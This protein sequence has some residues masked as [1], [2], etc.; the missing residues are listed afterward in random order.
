MWYKWKVHT[1]TFLSY[2]SKST[3]IVPQKSSFVKLLL[4]LYLFVPNLRI[5]VPKHYSSYSYLFLLWDEMFLFYFILFLFALIFPQ[6]YSFV[7][8]LL[9]QLSVPVCSKFEAM[10]HNIILNVP[11]CSYFMLFLSAVIVPQ[12]SSFAKL[13]IYLYLF[14]PNFRLNVPKHYS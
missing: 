14:V 5:N 12:K 3:R 4:Y 2:M 8:Q 11:I 10:F 7:K 6:K 1:Y 13:L 9:Y